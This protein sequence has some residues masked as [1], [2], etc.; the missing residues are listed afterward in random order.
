MRNLSITGRMR[1]LGGLLG[2]LALAGLIF[3]AQFQIRRVLF[4]A[5]D[6]A[7]VKQSE[8]WRGGGPGGPPEGGGRQRNGDGGGWDDQE[9][10]RRR[11]PPVIDFGTVSLLPPRRLSL[12]TRK[13]D[14]GNPP[15]SAEGFEAAR[16][17]GEDWREGVGPNG[18]AIRIY[19][20]FRNGTVTQTAATTAETEAALAE[21]NGAL[22]TML[23]VLA[24]LVGGLGALLIDVALAP[25]RRLG[26]AAASLS[27]GQ[28]SARLPAPG[29]ND[30]FDKLVQVL[31]GQLE[32]IEEAFV[33]Q[34]RFA[35][36]ASHELRTPLAVIKANTSLLLE[37]PETLS[38]P[39]KRLIVRADTTV[40][41]A[42]RLVED[43]LELARAQSGTLAVRAEP[44]EISDLLE[45]VARD[46]EAARPAPHASLSIEATPG[47]TFSLDAGLMARLLLN[48]TTNALRHTPENGSVTLSARKTES[49]GLILTV[50]DTGE[51]IPP[52]A[53]PRLGEPFFRPDDARA[54][55]QGG[56]GLGLALCKEIAHAHGG[57]LTFESVLGEGTTVTVELPNSSRH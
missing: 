21:I 2:A 8:T 36:D 14:E 41:R 48:L 52:E 29:G 37:T 30:A 55:S 50:R 47:E 11:E 7:L 10:P 57:T 39:Q 1:L 20:A 40:D 15:W 34:K 12:T 33:R 6:R 27:P 19:S 49:G 4:A 38:A 53:L 31:N 26:K 23:P 24:L 22:L 54:R 18:G 51:G 44:T 45:S 46:A 32:R 35:A 28:L 3:L 5:V 17:N 13:T 25:V 42:T 56:A 16:R 9:P 43:L